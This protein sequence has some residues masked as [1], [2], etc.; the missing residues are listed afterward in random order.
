[1]TGQDGFY[2]LEEQFRG[3]VLGKKTSCPTVQA[4]YE[5]LLILSVTYQDDP[6][7]QAPATDARRKVCPG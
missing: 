4:T 7:R 2:P 5:Q 1:M 3:R 6:R